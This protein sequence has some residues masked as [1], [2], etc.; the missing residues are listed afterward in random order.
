M[1]FITLSILL[2]IVSHPSISDVQFIHLVKDIAQIVTN[3][4]NHSHPILYEVKHHND[5]NYKV[6]VGTEV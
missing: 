6:E 5:I 1:E 3:F 4:E 2:F